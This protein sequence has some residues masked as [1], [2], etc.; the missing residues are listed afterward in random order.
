[1]RVA[2][3]GASG[4]MGR[5]FTEYFLSHGHE[6]TGFDTKRPSFS[7]SSF[8]RA[9][10]NADAVVGAQVV[11]VAVPIATTVKTV[12]EIAPQLHKGVH[13]IEISSIKGKILG[14]LRPIVR[15]TGASLVS[16]HPLFGP[17]LSASRGMK[18]CIIE[19]GKAALNFAKELFPDATLIPIREREH[20]KAMGIILSMTHLLNIAY[21]ATVAK[22]MTPEEFR[23]LESPTSAAQMSLAEGVLNQDPSLYS[24]IQLENDYSTKFAGD[25]V[26]QLER[27]R[28][29]LKRKDKKGFEAYF[30][31][32]SA[33]YAQDSKTALQSIYEAFEVKQS[34]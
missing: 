34:R 27:L 32:L 29:F 33:E 13:L 10:S 31:R 8:T 22:Y 6:V 5:F 14:E 3:L 7:D 24:Y 19:R 4:G 23:T 21:A 16:L 17:S 11:L 1:L 15:K 2:V 28:T 26:D 30:A 12:K 25:L 18:I 9:D 20:D